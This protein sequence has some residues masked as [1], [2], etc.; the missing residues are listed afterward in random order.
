[1]SKTADVIQGIKQ[2][3]KEVEEI[4]A[5]LRQPSLLRDEGL[6]NEKLKKWTNRAYEQLNAWGFKREAEDG[7][8]SNSMTH[9]YDGVDARAKMRDDKLNALLDDISS[10]P[11]HYETRLGHS[12]QEVDRKKMPKAQRIFLGHGRNKLWAR[13][14]IYLKDEL[15][16]SV[17]AWESNPRAGLHSVDV[18]NEVLDSCTF[19]VI[20]GTGEDATADGGLRARQNVVHEIGL[21]QGRLGF[22][23]VAL[24]QQRG[25][26]EFSNLAGLQVI[27]FS[28]LQVEETFYELRRMLERERVI[29]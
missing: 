15:H 3:R 7:F 6:L 10:H 21:F 27:P 24:L 17:E 20:I 9:M 12:Q 26:E 1:M 25:V 29:S 2:L 5:Q 28:G 22:K 4:R 14:H 16:L 8:G 18:L 11:E 23:K 13:V 19:A